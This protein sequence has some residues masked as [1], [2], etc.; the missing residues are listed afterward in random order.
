MIFWR[1]CAAPLMVDGELRQVKKIEAMADVKSVNMLLPD[2]WS[3]LWANELLLRRA[4][5][6]ATD[7]YEARWHTA[8]RGDWDLQ[9]GLIAVKPPGEARRQLTPR[10]A[11]VDTRSPQ[12]LRASLG[13]GWHDEES[14]AKSG[15]QWR[16][17]K[18]DA[19]IRIENPQARPL[20]VL[21]TVDGWSIGGERD[22][23]LVASPA[24]SNA[25]ATVQ[26][27]T[28]R[29]KIQLAPVVVPPGASVLT[30]QSLQP[31]ASAGPG[32]ARALGVCVFGLELAVR[33]D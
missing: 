33:P 13:D 32:D 30:L 9:G 26:L 20:T 27:G 22:L 21:C 31:P 24:A 28:Q 1:M 10:F 14:D 25:P 3:R 7:T 8:L 6:F 5:F 19:T 12:F 15:A 29:M 16:W 18:G 4:Q 23:A 17:T 11:L 2:M